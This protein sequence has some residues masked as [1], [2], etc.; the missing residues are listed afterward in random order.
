MHILYSHQVCIGG[1]DE[2][3]GSSS[4]G[5]WEFWVGRSENVIAHQVTEI[6]VWNACSECHCNATPPGQRGFLL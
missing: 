4:A 3:Q 2:K 6:L 1:K 5:V